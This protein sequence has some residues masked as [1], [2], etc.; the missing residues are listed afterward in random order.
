MRGIQ[1]RGYVLVITATCA[2]GICGALGLAVDVGRLYIVRNELQ[3]FTDSA[4]LA[5]AAEL[6]GTSAGIRRATDA[7]AANPNRW[8]LGSAAVTDSRIAFAKFQ[9]G[10]WAASPSPAAG[11]ICARVT[12][13][14]WVPLSFLPAVWRTAGQPVNASSV[15]A[16]IPK[17]RFRDGLMPFSPYAHSLAEGFGFIPGQQYAIRWPSNPR[18]N[19]NTCDGDNSQAW[20]DLAES[21]GAETRGYI[22]DSSADVI[23]SAIVENYQSRPLAVGD[24]VTM[25]N[26]NK[27]AERDA[28]QARIGQD[29]DQDSA[30]YAQYSSGGSGNGRRLIAAPVNTGYPDF[31]I[32]GFALFLLLPASTYDLSGNKPWCVEYVGPYVEGGRRQAGGTAGAYTARL[33]Q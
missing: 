19:V 8:N 17:T 26:G 18:L 12:A 4:A 31:R 29:S 13:G 28:L 24:T 7:A 5:A 14:A 25:T 16:Q 11:Y 22:E 21:A 10:P 6:D 9:S 30:S 2:V 3:T 1:Q 33:V 27:Q 20:I 32:V 23:R 15:A